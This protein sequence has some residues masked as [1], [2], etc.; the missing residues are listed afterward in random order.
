MK[1]IRKIILSALLLAAAVV[2][3]RFLS[4]N[5]SILSIGFTFV[6]LMLAGIILG[7]KYSLVIAGLADLIGALLFPFGSYFVGYTISS[8]LTGLVYGLFLYQKGV[9]VVNK[10]FLIRLV[11]AILIVCIFIN[12]GLNTLWLVITSKKATMAILPTRVIKQLIMIPVMFITIS[13]LGKLLTKQINEVK[14]VS[15]K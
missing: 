1:K 10:K 2:L 11:I 7:W 8:V 13:T 6:P 14:D 5:T 4:I 3:N 15:D 12:G 9:F